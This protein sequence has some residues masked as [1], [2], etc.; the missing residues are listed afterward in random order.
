MK[1][2]SAEVRIPHDSDPLSLALG[3]V[4]VTYE[5][6]TTEKL[7]EFFQDE[8]MFYRSE[9]TGLTRDQA[10]DLKHTKDVR[11]LRS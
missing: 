4:H 6:G 8:I 9:F 1:I 7:F 5:N 11:F 2:V 10:I 3:E